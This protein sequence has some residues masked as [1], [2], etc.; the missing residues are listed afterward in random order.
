MA[1]EKEG[2]VIK[3]VQRLKE[4][5]NL[6]LKRRQ[7]ILSFLR[8]IDRGVKERRPLRLILD[9]KGTRKHLTDL[10]KGFTPGVLLRQLV[11]QRIYGLVILQDPSIREESLV[12]LPKGVYL[13]RH[14]QG[15]DEVDLVPVKKVN[16]PAFFA[17]GILRAPLTA[18]TLT[19]R[20]DQAIG[21][22]LEKVS[23]R[24]T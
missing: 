11:V 6:E 24:V 17:D 12:L 10:G 16:H 2:G 23:P 3:G 14:P 9:E 15:E 20:F 18:D 8:Q 5:A 7:D 1:H 19:E 4:A 13:A 22:F 21:R